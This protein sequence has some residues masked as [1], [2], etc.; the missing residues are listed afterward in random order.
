MNRSSKR[1][2]RGA[3]DD[4]IYPPRKEL[5]PVIK[6]RNRTNPNSSLLSPM[7]AALAPLGQ[8]DSKVIPVSPRTLQKLV[9]LPPARSEAGAS[10]TVASHAFVAT[11]IGDPD[12]AVV[13]V[14]QS[15]L[16]ALILLPIPP[17]RR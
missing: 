2:T 4:S 11:E 1:T 7:H 12:S 5:D 13:P 3:A 9:R 15:I 17:N 10:G 8:P 14:S 6:P 16:S